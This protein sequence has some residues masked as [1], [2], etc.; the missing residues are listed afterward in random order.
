MDEPASHPMD[1]L[2]KA[3]VRLAIKR[4]HER[5]IAALLMT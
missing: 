4:E 5:Q 2:I 3:L 1:A